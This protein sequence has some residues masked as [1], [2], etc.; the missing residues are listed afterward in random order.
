VQGAELDG[1]PQERLAFNPVAGPIPE[2][3]AQ[4]E[5]RLKIPGMG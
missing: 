4:P 1:P 5:E 3:E 2:P